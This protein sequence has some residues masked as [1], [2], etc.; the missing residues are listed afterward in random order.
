VRHGQLVCINVA[1]HLA[2]T[3]FFPGTEPTSGMDPYSRRSTWNIIQRNKKGRII[4]LTTHFMDE[5]ECKMFI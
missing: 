1:I 2:N 3:L 4:L 5:G